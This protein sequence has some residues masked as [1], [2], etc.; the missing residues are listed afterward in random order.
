M[1]ESADP[2]PATGGGRRGRRNVPIL[3]SEQRPSDAA[4]V[5]R[6]CDSDCSRMASP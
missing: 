3:K 6:L 2:T 4:V 1:M 5:H